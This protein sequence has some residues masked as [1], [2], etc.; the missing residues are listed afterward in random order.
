MSAPDSTPRWV[1]TTL[2]AADAPPDVL[3]GRDN[4]R[5]KDLI[6]SRLFG[7]DTLVKIG[8]YTVLRPLGAGGMGMV[9][10]A[11]DEELDRRIA[12][13]LLHSGSAESDRHRLLREAQAMAKLSHPNVVTVHEVGTFEDQV[14]VAMEFVRGQTLQEWLSDGPHPWREI[15]DRFVFA[16]RGLAAAHAA[17]LVHRDFKPANV[18]CGDDGRVRVSDFGLVRQSGGEPG[19]PEEPPSSAPPTTTA[20]ATSLTMTGTI[21]GTPAYMSPEQHRGAPTDARSD[22]FSFCVALY[23]ALHGVHPFPGDTHAALARSVLDGALREPPRDSKVPPWVHRLLVR[24]L[25][26][27]P[28]DRWPT[29]D[30]LLAELERDTERRRRLRRGVA[31]V[32]VAVSAVILGLVWLAQERSEA[33]ALAAESEADAQDKKSLAEAD[34]DRALQEAL[35]ALADAEAQRKVAEEQRARAEAQQKLAEEQRALAEAQQKVAEEQRALAEAQRRDAEA[36]RAEAERQAERARQEARRARDA[37]R[38]AQ[39]LGTARDDPTTVL[40]LLRE[41]ESPAETPGWVPAA[42]LTLLKPVSQAVLRVHQGTVH[43]AVFS[44]DGRTLTTAADDGVVLRWAW[45]S[46]EVTRL[47][48]HE[49]PVLSAMFSKTGDEILTGSADGTARLW[50]IG[51]EPIRLDHGAPVKAAIYSPDERTLATAGQDGV[52]RLWTRDPEGRPGDPR[53]LRGHQGPIHAIAFAPGGRALAT[54]SADGTARVWELGDKGRVTV[55]GRP[56]G[57]VRALAWAPDGARLATAAQDGVI[58]V[59]TLGDGDPGAPVELR[60]H[61]DDVVAVAFTADGKSLISAG[62][63]G[64]ARIWRP[65][66]SGTPTVLR[67]HRGRIYSV[68]LGPGGV[69]LTASQDGTARLWDLRRPEA[70]PRSLVGHTEELS[71]ASLSADGRGIA[72]ASRDNTVR[73]WAPRREADDARVLAHRRPVA[74]AAYDPGGA[75]YL[76]CDGPQEVLWWDGA[77]EAPRRLAHPSPVLSAMFAEGGAAI[78][79]VAGDGVVRRFDGGGRVSELGDVGRREIRAAAHDP[80]R[81]RV[82]VATL[83]EVAW[84]RDLG[85]GGEWLLRGHSGT[86]HA[87]AFAQ[88]GALVATGASDRH[89][90]IWAVDEP[91]TSRT[92]GPHSGRVTAIAFNPA[93]DRVATASWDKRVRVWSVEGGAPEVVLTGHEGPVWSVAWS[94][95]GASLVTGAEDQTV[96]VWAADGRREP[97][98]LAGHEGPVRVAVFR[99]DGAA[100]LSGGDDRSARIWNADFDPGSLQRRLWR[101]S[102]VC[103]GARERVRLLGEEPASAEAAARACVAEARDHGR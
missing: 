2:D 64:T 56:K 51:A 23:E 52:V 31:G 74:C 73:V 65:D 38:L 86:I 46:G 54:A 69:L 4:Q 8:R 47:G 1:S 41:T 28:A 13:K 80:I 17:G 37:T 66:G 33:A 94:P 100:I 91:S 60:G 40:A 35:A 58:R 16:G 103:L 83:V 88:D 7:G 72:T 3:A 34:R 21:M 87:L 29:I 71:S 90:R 59:W 78:V 18:L 12:V 30:A 45:E 22:Q 96:R 101:A 19:E 44:P 50:K 57:A 92:L 61:D 15:A 77:V 24:G 67:G 89:A 82:A 25:A 102:P 5:I 93:G 49:G 48:A 32:F 63:D 11:Y 10:A 62:L 26:V 99:P 98:V 42:A 39:A 6:K 85:S 36:Q 43:S 14:Y 81:R 76:T 97:V 9:Y 79:T 75:A 53:E 84:L 68:A 55:L 20:L 70:R 95:D 27:D